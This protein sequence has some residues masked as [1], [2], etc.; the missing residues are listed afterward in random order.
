LLGSSWRLIKIPP[1]LPAPGVADDAREA[2]LRRRRD[3]RQ[4]FE[5]LLDTLLRAWHSHFDFNAKG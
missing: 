1:E 4:A 3:E 5:D 2:V